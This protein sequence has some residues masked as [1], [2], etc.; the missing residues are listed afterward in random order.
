[1]FNLTHCSSQGHSGNINHTN[2]EQGNF[3]IKKLTSKK[4]LTAKRN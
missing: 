2:F 3:N 1:M 4:W